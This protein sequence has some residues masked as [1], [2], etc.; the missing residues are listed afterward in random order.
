MG[1]AGNS[2]SSVPSSSPSLSLSE[3]RAGPEGGTTG[4]WC[5]SPRQEGQKRRLTG[6]EGNTDGLVHAKEGLEITGDA[7]QY[8]PHEEVQGEHTPCAQP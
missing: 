2:S 5:L 1:R 3:E 4:A 8:V 6:Q 7:E